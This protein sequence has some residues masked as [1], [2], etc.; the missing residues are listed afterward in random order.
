[1]D[2]LKP[3]HA[4]RSSS[5]RLLNNYLDS[6][7]AL[8]TSLLTLLSHSHSSTSSLLAYV[9]SSPGVL[10]SVRRSVRH[11][12][13]EGPLT[14]SMTDGGDVRESEGGWALY[15]S[16]LDQFRRDL[17]EIH[18]LE[19]EISRVKRDREI[20]VSRLIKATK[21]R[22]TKSDLSALAN[23]YAAH[24]DILQSS[25]ASVLSDNSSVTSKEGKRASKLAGA[26]A[27]LLGCEEHLRGLEARIE[28]ERN[29]VMARGL[30]DRFRAMEV[31]GR[32]WIQQARKGLE[33]L[34]KMHDLPADAFELDSN[35]SLAPSQSA[36]QIAYEDT[37]GQ[38]PSR[39]GV[40]FP[41]YY[42]PGGSM[43]RSIAEENE[44]AS[45]SEEDLGNIAVHENTLISNASPLLP[46]K[47]RN[48]TLL[49]S[50]LVVSSNGTR[51]RPLSDSK[52]DRADSPDSPRVNGRRA[53]SD[54]GSGYRPPSSRAR[55]ASLRRTYSHNH[56]AD[57]D[58]SSI[59]AHKS[60]K[61]GFFAS[62]S[63]LFK[64]R[65]S[66]SER[67]PS[68][69]YGSRG[70][71][72]W[73]TRTDS[74]LKRVSTLRGRPEDSSSDENEENFVSVSN[75]RNSNWMVDHRSS[76]D[77]VKRNSSMPIATG[78]I[79]PKPTHSTSQSTIT[80]KSKVSTGDGIL[81]RSGTLKSN[82][83]DATVKSAGTIK[84][85]TRPN[86]SI[87]RSKTGNGRGHP[88]G[89]GAGVASRNI[90][91]LF[92]AS[93]QTTMPEVP[94]AP[95]SSVDP[96][97]EMPKAP[98]SSIVTANASVSPAKSKRL[99]YSSTTASPSNVITNKSVVTEPS[100]RKQKSRVPGAE[101]GLDSPSLRPTTPLP[102]SR[103]LSP[104]LKSALRPTS[105]QPQSP[106]EPVKPMYTVSAPAPIA[107]DE[108]KLKREVERE[109]EEVSQSETDKRNSFM[110]MQ[111]D[112][113]SVY[114]SAV[115]DDEDGP[116]GPQS[117]SSDEEEAAAA[118]SKYK[119]IRNE[120]VSRQ[121]EMVM[122][123]THHG[124]EDE[125][126]DEGGSQVTIGA[127]PERAN[128]T[129]ATAPIEMAALGQEVTVKRR[130]SVRMAVP[131]SPITE[132]TPPLL[133]SSLNHTPHPSRPIAISSDFTPRS[134]SPSPE[135]QRV[136][137]I[138]ST[139]INKARE[140]TSEEEDENEN[141]LK[142]RKELKRNSGK[143]A[144]VEE[145]KAKADSLKKRGSVKSKGSAKF[146][147]SKK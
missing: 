18:K 15:I 72:G 4:H 107:L 64:P 84:K 100:S 132:M 99:S 76:S 98:G 124:R 20:L 42:D 40:P 123:N 93:N 69:V 67:S 85:K 129:D 119:I 146:R 141:Y 46:S 70:K 7:K 37:P 131:D 12:A 14:P 38:S 47:G 2:V 22:P 109:K 73:S 61:K 54:I 43:S 62:I 29:K 125:D 6:Q 104:P 134:R 74:N 48:T 28:N 80:A 79:P 59:R 126:G 13:F 35:G 71:G 25:A 36:S 53:A 66:V 83:S 55:A 128:G 52:Y 136:E 94:K 34:D 139:R 32:M 63:K 135:P 142:A 57:S 115:E 97:I 68:P 140:D 116:Y 77:K 108:V 60:K 145:A 41:R 133:T 19:E 65:K 45:S 16:S 21:G 138:W 95:K 88:P 26:Q 24:P 111:S 27:E 81:S 121:G 51:S 144:A 117:D 127:K 17:K 147:G 137:Q 114:E 11:A 91:T 106:Q 122:D 39:G 86:G 96:Y 50:P 1:M 30:E 89:Q 112:N 31:V 113:A 92:D 105:P 44:G 58:T 143:W 110:S 8:S 9:T 130:K 49:S 101:P 87:A 82:V 23:S 75:N 5:D 90:M 10:I 78:L 33:D 3:G 102:P 118:Q 120:R 103:T 56:Y